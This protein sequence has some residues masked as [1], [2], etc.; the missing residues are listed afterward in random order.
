MSPLLFFYQVCR[1]IALQALAFCGEEGLSLLGCACGVSVFPLL[2]AGVE[3]LPLHSTHFKHVKCTNL[4]G[5]TNKTRTIRRSIEFLTL[6]FGFIMGLD[7]S[8]TASFPVC[9]FYF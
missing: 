9:S 7:I 8:V 4:K 2:P 1:S 3:C 6:L 5:N